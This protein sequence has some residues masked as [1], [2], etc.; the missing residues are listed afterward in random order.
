M[1]I[2]GG[3]SVPSVSP[4]LHPAAV[5]TPIVQLPRRVYDGFGFVS[6]SVSMVARPQ[7]AD[8]VLHLMRNAR[9]EGYAV[10]MRGSG[11]SYGD[12]A[13]NGGNLVLDMT[14]MRRVLAWDPATGVIDVEPGV[15]IE[16]LWR[17]CLRDGWWPAVVPGTMFPT[18]GGC[19][20]MNIH[21]KNHFRMG[22]TGDHVL[23]ADLVTPGGEHL[24][25]S[26]TEN[27][28]FFHAAIG[29]FGML[30]TFTRV[31]LQLKKVESGRLAV[32]QVPARNLDEQFEYFEAHQHDSDYLVSW[33]DCIASGAGLGRG[34]IHRATYL[35]A[36]DDPAGVPMLDPARQDLPG[37]ILGVPRGLVGSL[38]GLFNF[39][40]GMRFVN[41]GKYYASVL[42]PRSTYA[43]PHVAFHF[44]LD[45]VPTWR[46]AYQP[47]GFLQYQPFLPKAT[48]K[49][50][51]TDILRLNHARGLVS[52]LGVLKRY[53]PDDFLLSHALDGYSLAMD[54]AV[55]SSN[56]EAL[57]KM[58]HEMNEIV[59]AAGGRFY[60]AKD[61]VMRPSDFQRAWGQERVGAFRALRNRADPDR[62]LRTELAE[63][64]GLDQPR[65]A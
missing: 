25:L 3:M 51:L 2:V 30:G 37:T 4:S 17:L 23:E 38:L 6:R 36:H 65:G 19:L 55:T 57:W 32:Q 1:A 53:R 15:T 47:G 20:A 11:R 18:I 41:M 45:Y 61:A 33:V 10:A 40:L 35:H 52:Y 43:Q 27:P 8:E 14:G 21:G 62:I 44:L 46:N 7:S 60:P 13:M 54:F 5:D 28:D 50:A 16:D 26:R 31:R 58:C 29:G 24:R 39:N 48:A 59:L 49:Q 63:R 64:I 42:S 34:Q 12:A 22:G 9:A 56:R